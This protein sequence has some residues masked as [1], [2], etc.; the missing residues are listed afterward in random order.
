L[1]CNALS[2]LANRVLPKCDRKYGQPQQRPK[3][4]ALTF[5][6]PLLMRKWHCLAYRRNMGHNAALRE[7]LRELELTQSE[8]AFRMNTAIEKLTGRYG[9]VS[10]R[11]IYDMLTGK[12]RWPQTRQR[13][14]LEAV[15]G[16]TVEELGFR[17]PGLSHR[18][19]PRPEQPVKRRFFLTAAAGT[20]SSATMPF[21][22]AP[23]AVGTT[24]VIR[25]RTV[26]D[27][28]VGIDDQRGG[29]NAL[30]KAALA[31]ASRA[32]DLQQRPASERT[33]ERLYSLAADFTTTAA[34]SCIDSFALERAQLHLDQA[35]TLAGL[36]QD[37]IAQLHV[38]NSISFL[39]L[40]RGRPHEAVAA[41]RAA[42]STTSIRQDPFLS[43]L[44]QARAATGLAET[45]DRQA[46]LRSVGRAVD[47]LGRTSDKPRPSWTAFYGLGE[48]E[49]IS[50]LVY[51]Q[52]DSPENA[53]AAAHR[54]LS[55]TP[56]SF[57]RNQ[58]QISMYLA[59]AQLG[60]GDAELACSSA[61]RAIDLM[62]GNPV[63]GRMR[64]LLGDFHRA[65]IAAAPNSS[66]SNEWTERARQEWSRQV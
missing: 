53:E 5:P 32:L 46:A 13:V 63:P 22:A 29:H 61:H 50:T 56:P 17:P 34:F 12:T 28:L 40:Y 36:S 33:R 55:A 30:E 25:L 48:I 42:Q 27:N 8:L 66:V 19:T 41:T 60:Q 59:K 43:S 18:P 6:L 35:S 11:T 38:W 31:G 65:L 26:L 39:A 21:L 57:R 44:A 15:F 16:C 10:E 23:P 20:V 37:P 24:D 7:H 58:A 1:L 2:S 49:C 4:E 3:P 45:G 52:L 54:A 9:T 14:A 64:T 62:D 47:T 51:H